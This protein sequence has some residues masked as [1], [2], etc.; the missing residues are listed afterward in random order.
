MPSL[1]GRPPTCGRI[2]VKAV[3]GM[4]VADMFTQPIR[5]SWHY[6][7]AANTEE[8]KERTQLS[9]EPCHQMNAVD[10]RTLSPDERNKHGSMHNLPP[11]STTKLSH[12]MI[13]VTEK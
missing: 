2:Q 10:N 3:K 13:A 7:N 4:S 8:H 9:T 1:P 5:E 12:R 6:D 11:Q